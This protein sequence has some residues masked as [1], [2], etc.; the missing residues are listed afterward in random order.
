MA[1][2][3]E[4]LSAWEIANS[5]LTTKELRRLYSKQAYTARQR[6]GKIEQKYGPNAE[7]V[8]R[9]AGDFQPLSKLP[10][11]MTRQQIANELSST[12]KFLASGS[13]RV[14][15]YGK[16]RQQIIESFQSNGYEFVN[17][18]NLA[19]FGRFMNSVR[20][21]HIAKSFPSDQVAKLYEDMEKKGISSATMERHF[22]GYLASQEG[23]LDLRE[24]LAELDLPEHRKRIS[25]TEVREKMKDLGLWKE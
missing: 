12:Q 6:L 1:K 3:I 7:I 11:N 23:I 15:E 16:V 8:Q 10:K 22:K 2:R 5:S 20:E 14:S 9:R 24:A 17:E 13:S 18:D 19:D 21:K 25:S 4:A